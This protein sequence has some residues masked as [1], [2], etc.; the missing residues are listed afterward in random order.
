MNCELKSMNITIPDYEYKEL[1]YLCEKEG[2]SLNEGI[3]T[4][5]RSASYQASVNQIKIINK[6]NRFI[7]YL[8]G[9]I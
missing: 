6:N 5:I 9:K 1:V 3:A 2:F 7:N 8:Y 4:L